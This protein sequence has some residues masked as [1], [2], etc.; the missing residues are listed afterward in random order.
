MNYND[1]D[2]IELITLL[3]ENDENVRNIIY[4]KYSYLVDILIKKYQ[5]AIRY[6]RINYDEIKCEALYAFSDGIH[7]FT[8]TK[9][10]SLKTFLY[11][12]IERRLLNYI[13]HAM[14]GKQQTINES[15]SLDFL[16]SDDNITPKNLLSDENKSNPL[17]SLMEKENSNKIYML[18]KNNLSEFEYTVFNYMV[19]NFSYNEIAKIMGKSPKQIDNAIKRIKIK[20]KDLIEKEG[21]I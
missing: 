5:R 10:A 14:S 2:D 1:I 17:H 13:R 15:L 12:C 21:L 8:S 3:E 18:A 6:Y 11:V 20:M 19:N 7:S 9:Y 4:D 16:V